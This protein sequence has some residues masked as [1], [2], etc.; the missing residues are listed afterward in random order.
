MAKEEESKKMTE[1]FKDDAQENCDEQGSK[2]VFYAQSPSAV[3]SGRT[4]DE[5]TGG[6]REDEEEESYENTEGEREDEEF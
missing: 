5:D 2:L 4:C 3:I 1:K 6:Q